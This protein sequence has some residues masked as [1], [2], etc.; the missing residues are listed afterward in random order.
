M[1]HRRFGSAY[2]A[3]I[4]QLDEGACGVGPGPLFDAD[5]LADSPDYFFLSWGK[6]A[7]IKPGSCR[8]EV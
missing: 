6:I 7:Q 2:Q 5:I 4:A 1:S 3:A 8:D